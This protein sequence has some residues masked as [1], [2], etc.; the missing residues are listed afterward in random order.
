MQGSGSDGLNNFGGFRRS[1]SFGDSDSFGNSDSTGGSRLFTRFDRT[2]DDPERHN[3]PDDF[4]SDRLR[5]PYT[6]TGTGAST[7]NTPINT[8]TTVHHTTEPDDHHDQRPE[9]PDCEPDHDNRGKRRHKNR[10]AAGASCCEPPSA[11][12]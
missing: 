12:A 11:P 7:T 10:R 2:K 4:D 3:R 1:G 9:C 6:S 8:E 5:R